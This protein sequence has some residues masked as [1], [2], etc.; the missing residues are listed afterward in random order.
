MAP[1]VRTLRAFC[2]RIL[3]EGDLAAKLADPGPLDDACP[4]RPLH[5]EL[6]ARAPE[7]RLAEGSERLPRSL[8]DEASRV[9]C[10]HRFAHHELMAVELLAWALLRWPSAAAGLRADW[11]ATLRDEQRHAR[12]YLGRLASY[13]TK[14]G[15][16]PLGDYFWRH[17]PALSRAP[18][19]PLG[20]V[21]A[22]GLTLEQANLDFSLRY[23]AAF[24]AA[25]DP[26]SARVLE[27]VHADERAHVAAAARWLERLKRP[28]ER[29]VDAYADSVPFPLG[30]ARA[31]GRPFQL[32]A[33]RRAGLSDA[34]IEYVRRA[35]S[36]QE[37]GRR[38]PAQ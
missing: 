17:V 4:G 20:F 29:D 36:P 16:E 22:L 7:L 15:D 18:R 24:R 21:S 27:R 12:L 3:N 37:R 30:A 28:G 8:A 6:P 10:L 23:A 13:G 33:R 34:L 19:G 26:D 14:L 1:P 11:L 32:E 35:R 9:R 25:G 38:S 2:L 31:K 5:V